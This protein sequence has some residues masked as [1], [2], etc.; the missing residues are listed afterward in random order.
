MCIA[1]NTA[2]KGNYTVMLTAIAT[3]RR[4]NSM[5]NAEKKKDS[6]S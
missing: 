4:E 5:K 1:V 2:Q 3:T 6:R